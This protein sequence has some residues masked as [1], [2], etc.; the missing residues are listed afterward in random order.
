MKKEFS[1]NGIMHYYEDM[2]D[3]EYN[4]IITKIN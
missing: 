1:C 4:G 3:D 2:T